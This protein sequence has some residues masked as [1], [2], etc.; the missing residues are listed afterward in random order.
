MVNVLILDLRKRRRSVLGGR[1]KQS[2][3]ALTLSLYK[4][5][6]RKNRHSR[7]T[8]RIGS[9]YANSLALDGMKRQL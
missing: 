4:R 9:S 2:I 1:L 6:S 3:E 5:L 8:I 7:A